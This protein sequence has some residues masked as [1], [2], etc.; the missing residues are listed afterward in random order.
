MSVISGDVTPVPLVVVVFIVRKDTIM[1]GLILVPVVCMNMAL[2][3]N[4]VQ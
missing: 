1:I 3:V 2:L 4:I